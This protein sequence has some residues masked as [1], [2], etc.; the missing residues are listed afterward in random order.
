MVSDFLRNFF[1]FVFQT[2][3]LAVQLGFFAGVLLI[4][5]YVVFNAFSNSAVFRK[6]NKSIK[7]TV[8]RIIDFSRVWGPNCLMVFILGRFLLMFLRLGLS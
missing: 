2:V 1:L 8:F 7:N 4:L 3:A 5:L 6:S